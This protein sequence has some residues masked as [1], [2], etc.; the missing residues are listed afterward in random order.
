MYA[1]GT[2]EGSWILHGLCV[3]CG[4]R[5]DVVTNLLK[6]LAYARQLSNL[7]KH[8]QTLLKEWVVCPRF[9]QLSASCSQM[10]QQHALTSWRMGPL[11]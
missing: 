9:Q 10:D 2:K 7:S 5:C 11:L 3:C 8:S 6:H 1:Q 4:E